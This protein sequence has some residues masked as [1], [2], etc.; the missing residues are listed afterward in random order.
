MIGNE[1]SPIAMTVAPTIPVLAAIRAP[2]NITEMA[3]LPLKP[4]I[5]SAILLNKSCARFDFSRSTPINTNKGTATN[6]MLVIS[7]YN[8][9]GIAPRNALSKV[10]VKTPP[11]A[12]I[13]AVPASEKATGN[14]A[15]RTKQIT[16][17]INK[18]INSTMLNN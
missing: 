16:P 13:S 18:G 12:N 11:A 8:L 2:T 14:P 15:N 1:I 6:V 5:T 7:P 9:F 4:P 3:K 17:N 10:P